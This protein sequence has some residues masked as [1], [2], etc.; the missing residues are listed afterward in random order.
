MA[1][2]SSG[3]GFVPHFVSS[4]SVFWSDRLQIAGVVTVRVA[5]SAQL[6]SYGVYTIGVHA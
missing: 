4:V 2:V 3:T 1:L 6:E 5:A